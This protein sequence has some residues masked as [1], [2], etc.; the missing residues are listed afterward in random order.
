MFIRLK[1]FGFN[2]YIKGIIVILIVLC[3]L[4]IQDKPHFSS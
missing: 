1:E 3:V 4:I 2:F